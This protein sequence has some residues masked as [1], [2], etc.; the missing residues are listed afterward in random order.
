MTIST[1]ISWA[2][3]ERI[4][5]LQNR[6]GWICRLGRYLSAGYALWTLW[7]VVSFWLNAPLVE[8]RFAALAGLEAHSVSAATRLAGFSLSF[9]SWIAVAATCWAGWRLF[10]A[11]L[12]GRI[13]TPDSADLLRRTTLFGI[14]AV[15][16]DVAIRPMLVW[17]VSGVFPQFA[18][19]PW[20]YFS[21]ND[22][23][24]LIFLLSLFAI[25]HIFKVA[26]ELAAE[27]AEIL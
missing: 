7:L 13:F 8:R 20:Y 25:A 27:N 1:D 15:L 22:L 11:Y 16:I 10:S 2:M 5:T 23:A 12:G 3:P 17:L 6:I 26:A 19:A 14:A 21:P 18:K 9:V 4:H 24:L